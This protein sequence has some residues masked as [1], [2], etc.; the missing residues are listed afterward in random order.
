MKFNALVPSLIRTWV[1][2]FVGQLVAWLVTLGIISEGT[3]TPEMQAG[4]S[5]FLGLVLTGAYYTVIRLLEQRWPQIGILLGST[6]QPVD[7]AS[8]RDVVEGN[9]QT[10]YVQ[11]SYDEQFGT[12]PSGVQ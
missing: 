1:P 8:G 6:Q 3:I 12:H 4:L 11:N 5:G 9:I 2:L 10:T 7:Y